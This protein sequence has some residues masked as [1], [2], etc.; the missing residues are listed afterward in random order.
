MSRRGAFGCLVLVAVLSL[1]D[2]LKADG[3]AQ[4]QYLGL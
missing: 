1:P 4:A 2:E 3:A